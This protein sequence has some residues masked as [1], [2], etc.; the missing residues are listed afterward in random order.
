MY[1]GLKVLLKIKGTPKRTK[2]LEI[3]FKN[4]KGIME[5]EGEDKCA[6]ILLKYPRPEDQNVFATRLNTSSKNWDQLQAI[7]AEK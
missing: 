5:L 4:A 6:K 2:L 3:C 7:M 1:R